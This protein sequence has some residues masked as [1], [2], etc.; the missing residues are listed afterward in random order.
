M[1]LSDRQAWTKSPGEKAGD[2]PV[3]APVGWVH[4]LP[5]PCSKNQVF[6]NNQ[7]QEFQ[8]NQ[9]Q[10]LQQPC[11]AALLSVLRYRC[12]CLHSHACSRWTGGD[13]CDSPG[14]SSPFRAVVQGRVWVS[15]DECKCLALWWV[16]CC[17]HCGIRVLFFLWLPSNV[18]RR[19]AL[20]ID[21]VLLFNGDCV[22]FSSVPV[23]ISFS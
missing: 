4:R 19:P 8:Q 14:G 11:R 2:S 21:S 1:L 6:D 5:G 7:V 20:V 3:G 12:L 9:V 16:K 17:T 15:A 22:P 13:V 18:N 10:E 23:S